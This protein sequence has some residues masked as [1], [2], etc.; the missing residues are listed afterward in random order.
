[1]NQHEDECGW[2][3]RPPHED[4]AAIYPL[5][6]WRIALY[7]HDTMGLGHLRRNLLIARIIAAS[8]LRASILLITGAREASAFSMPPGVDCLSLPSLSKDVSGQYFSRSLDVSLPEL[9]KLR[10]QTIA[11]AL[12]T[13]D[14]DLLIADKA[15]RGA[16]RELEPALHLLRDRGRCSCVLGLRDIL[17]DPATI[18]KEWSHEANLD[19]IHDYYSRVWVYGDP[20]IYDQ[21]REYEYP[22]FV[23]AKIRY[24]GYLVRPIQPVLSEN[25]SAELLALHSSDSDRLVLC[26]V[27]GGQDGGPLAEAFVQTEF[28]PGHRGVIVTGPFMPPDIQQRIIRLASQNAP[29][30]VLKFVTDSDLL[31]RL[32][33]RV[34]AMGGYN[35]VFDALSLG[36]CLLIVPRRTPRQEQ[37]LR[38]LR[39]QELGF[40]HALH[41]DGLSPEALSDWVRREHEPPSPVRN[42]IDLDGASKLVRFLEETLAE[43]RFFRSQRAQRSIQ[44]AF[45]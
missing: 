29:V 36:K 32:A 41:P 12:E 39:L 37:L 40:A 19:A 31:L 13:F 22:P 28:P 6:K 14:P 42:R 25:D 45:R 8:H 5:S 16:Q 24:T 7:S 21:V 9:V 34:I 17:D 35:T 26:L 43:S 2:Q 15:P 10:S 4:P 20:A 18:R 11:A 38:A 23:A 30:K 3:N 33:D 1:M 27:G 44:Y